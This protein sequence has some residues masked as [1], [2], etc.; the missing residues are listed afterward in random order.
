MVQA[1]DILARISKL[2]LEFEAGE[3]PAQ[4]AA[5]RNQLHAQ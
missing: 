3:S 2:A 1:D 4:I 5:C